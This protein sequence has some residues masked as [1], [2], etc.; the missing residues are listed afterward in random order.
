VRS[1]FVHDVSEGADVSG[2]AG[3]IAGTG[4][5][6][7]ATLTDD[8]LLAEQC[9]LAAERRRIDARAAVVAAEVARRSS[10]DL[11]HLG[12]AARQG[13]RSADELLQ[14]LTGTGA[15]DSR[16]LVEV[17]AL[18]AADTSADPAVAWLAPVAV[19]VKSGRVG[20]EAANA[21]RRG[22]GEPSATVSP[23]A[24]TRAA[25]RLISEIDLVGVDRLNARA[26]EERDA[27]DEAGVAEREQARF[28]RRSLR[29]SERWDGMLAINGLCD[30]ESGAL[31]KSALDT[32]LAPRRGGPRFIDEADRARAAAIEADPRTD[33]QLLHDAFIAMIRIATGADDGT[34]FGSRTPAVRVHATLH[35]LDRRAGSARIEGRPDAVT[36][37]TVDRHIC[38]SG[39]VPILFDDSDRVL[40]VG[41]RQRLFTARQR[42]ALA[43][44]DGGCRWPGCSA[45]ASWTESHHIDP[46][47][48]GGKTDVRDGIL[49]CRFHHM[50]VHNLGWRIRRTGGDYFAD[51]PPH[52]GRISTPLPLPSKSTVPRRTA[53]H[54]AEAA[55]RQAHATE[56]HRIGSPPPPGPEPDHPPGHDAGRHAGHSPVHHA[57]DKV[58]RRD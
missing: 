47:Q 5:A 13:A 4:A 41:R 20:V 11:G 1:A 18:L 14:R 51:P 8:A 12:L 19:A 52:P 30:P 49:L 34:V 16:T 40:D 57:V 35:D 42:I 24:L 25:E 43:A 44:R 45:P 54:A 37:E 50:H 9:H 7:V 38:E 31:V 55:R 15:R 21:I 6:D 46:W 26:R 32:V 27:V 36:L 56:Q 53:P 29:I 22:L 23:D 48:T 33:E 58:T 28:A 2:G 39:L 17:G 3:V 10:R